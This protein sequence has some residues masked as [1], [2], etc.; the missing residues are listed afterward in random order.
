MAWQTNVE[1]I[2]KLYIAFYG[3]PA[4]PGGLRYWASQLPD[5]AAPDSPAVRDLIS[6][7]INSQEAQDRFGSPSLNSTVARVYTYAFH[8]D[9]T[10][11]DKAKYAGKTVVDVLVDVLSVSYGPDYGTLNEKLQYAKWFTNYLDP[12]GDGIPNDDA[13]G[14]KFAATFFGNTDAETAKSKLHD[15]WLGNPAVQS[16]VLDDV[17]SIADTGDYILT[18]PP[19]TGRTFT[20]TAGVDNLTG[21][22]GDDTFVADDTQTIKVTSAADQ[23]NGGAGTDTLII[24]G[25]PNATPQITSIENVVLDSIGDGGS[26]NFA[27]VSGVEKMTISRAAGAATVTVADGV[28]VTLVN[29]L[30]S[31]KDISIGF[32]A[33]DTAASLTL[34]KVNIGTGNKLDLSSGGAKVGTV[35]LATTGSASTVGVLKMASA[36]NKLVITGDKDLTIATDFQNSGA[37]TVDASA[38]TGKLNLTTDDQITG[39][40]TAPG[41]VVKGGSNNDTIDIRNSD[42]FDYVS[43]TGGDGND[44]VIVK[45]DQIYNDTTDILDG[46]NGTDTLKV[47]FANSSNG[48]QK[49]LSGTIKGFDVLEVTSDSTANKTHT[50]DMGTNKLGITQFVVDGDSGDSFSFTGLAN[51]ANI[52][53]KSNQA[54]VSA[55]IGTNT[56]DDTISFVLDGTTIHTLT[57]TDY[58]TV[59]IISQKDSSGNTNAIITGSMT[60]AKIVNLSGSGNLSGGTI[61]M[62]SGATFN[63]ASFSGDLTLTFGASVKSYVGGS[64]KDEITLVT[65]DLKQG[66]TFAGNDGVDTLKVTTSANQNMGI[67]GL[68]GFEIVQLKINGAVVGDFR[69]VS[70]LNTLKVLTTAATDDLTLN[71]LQPDTTVS[72]GSNIDQ[73]TTTVNSGT[74]QKVAFHANATVNTLTLDPGTETLIVTSDDGD[75]IENEAMGSFTTISGTSLTKIIVE[76]KDQTNL[77]TLSSTVTTVDASAAK[78]ALTVTASNTATTIIGSQVADSITGGNGNDIIRGGKGD[79]TLDGGGGSDTYV[80]EATAAANGKDTITMV[81]GASGDKLNF[82]AFFGPGVGSVDQKGGSGT[83]INA[84]TSTDTK[85]VN[86]TN[87]VALYSDPSFNG[88]ANA[89]TVA[90]LI[91]GSGNAFSLTA[92]GKAIIITGDASSDD[93]KFQIW[94]IDDTL[95]GTPG[96][97]TETD[98]ACVGIS[99]AGIDL[100]TLITTNFLFS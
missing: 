61:T 45:I 31:N 63:A 10:D 81:A 39:T 99:S 48:F 96:M 33:N 86:I 3:R 56:P 82:A 60:A 90:G 8:R 30:A 34:D 84:Y 89:L 80:F 71:R 77:G 95:D 59:N 20:L 92:G 66:N 52:T 93:D 53:V 44:I 64:G 11:A 24:Y 98:V 32:G 47:D 26:A 36:T 29:N 35:N 25:T 18:N 68:T 13:T 72:F 28:A 94:Y 37:V 49:D 41:L 43:V 67:I 78:G 54:G 91:E 38:F 17:K 19:V 22:S 27:G 42:A 51:N 7:F 14:T 55:A 65:G 15:I 4:D 21:T 69:N 23:I 57:A 50:I 1:L 100:D 12:N 70:G 85:D 58:E 88:N 6:R 97:V 76:G 2:Q 40:P 87:K 9:A 5:N 16:K 79:D 73:V 62:A 75:N 74:T 46:G 83:A